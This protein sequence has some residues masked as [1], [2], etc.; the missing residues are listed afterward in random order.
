MP[1]YDVE[2]LPYLLENETLHDTKLGEPVGSLNP[3]A[4]LNVIAFVYPELS[5]C[6]AFL[7]AQRPPSRRLPSFQGSSP[8]KAHNETL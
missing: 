5:S 3:L 7:L 1:Q 2:H 4:D 6:H 8:A